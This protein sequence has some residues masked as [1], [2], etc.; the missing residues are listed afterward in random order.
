MIQWGDFWDF[1]TDLRNI[2]R[3][4]ADRA[5]L[6]EQIDL[7]T[8]SKLGG[9]FSATGRMAGAPA[10]KQIEK[11]KEEVA[12]IRGAER[13]SLVLSSEDVAGGGRQV[14]HAEGVYFVESSDE[15]ALLDWLW[16]L[17]FRSMA[18]LY[19]EDNPLGGGAMGDAARG[20]F[21]LPG[22]ERME[23]RISLSIS[24]IRAVGEDWRITAALAGE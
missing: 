11:M 1:H 4:P 20:L 6:K 21:S 22:L 3:L 5:Y 23:Q 18:P 14:L 2:Q 12:L 24:D 8:A 19:N 15:I 9:L 13:L 7:V 17:G 10:D 16:E